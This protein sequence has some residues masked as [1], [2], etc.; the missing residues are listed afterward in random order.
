MDRMGKHI[1]F[2]QFLCHEPAWN[3]QTKKI[4]GSEDVELAKKILDEKFFLVGTVE[5]F[6]EFLFL[7]E[8]KLAPM[9]FDIRHSQ[10]NLARR[11][12]RVHE[13][14]AKYG[15]EI[16]TRNELDRELYSYVETSLLPRYE[17]EYGKSYERD[18]EQFE[19]N[20]VTTAEPLL[21]RRID[22]VFRK[23]YVEPV[24]GLIRIINGLPAAGSY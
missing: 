4:S 18:Y 1:S 22:Y 3:F 8:K 14:Y 13:L 2:E 5:R 10:K 12:G 23:C 11:D 19:S 21:R 9:P 7:L 17:A 6:G 16:E 24:G 20:L 15:N